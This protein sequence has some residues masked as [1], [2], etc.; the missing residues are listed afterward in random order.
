M[1]TKKTLRNLTYHLLEEE[2]KIKWR[3]SKMCEKKERDRYGNLISTVDEKGRKY[4]KNGNHAGYEDESGKKY[5]KNGNHA[6]YEDESGK[7]YD[8][9]GKYEGY[10]EKK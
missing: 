9:N 8:R 2:G 5:D 6:G 7:K 1:A 10:E 3:I 4:D